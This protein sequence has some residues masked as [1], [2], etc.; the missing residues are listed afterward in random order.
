MHVAWHWT[1]NSAYQPRP[2]NQAREHKKI[3]R[4]IVY[5]SLPWIELYSALY[6]AVVAVLTLTHISSPWSQ[7]RLQSHSGVEECSREKHNKSKW[8]AHKLY[9]DSWSK[10]YIRHNMLYSTVYP[11]I[12]IIYIVRWLATEVQ[13]LRWEEHIY[14]CC[15]HTGVRAGS[16]IHRKKLTRTRGAGSK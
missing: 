8:C 1:R 12:Y 10:S 16:K 9:H 7:D 14:C 13:P 3:P 2:T 6:V 4:G 5:S 11:R 15:H